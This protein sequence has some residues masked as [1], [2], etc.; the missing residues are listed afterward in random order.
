[1]MVGAVVWFV[2]GLAANRIFFYPPVL[3]ILGIVAVFKG[4]TGRE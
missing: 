2:A 4:I 1:M 3:F